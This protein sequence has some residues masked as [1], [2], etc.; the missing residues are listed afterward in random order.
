M[1]LVLWDLAGEDKFL[2]V[3]PSHLRGLAGYLLVAD[4]T[5]RTTIEQ[6]LALRERHAARLDAVPGLLLINKRDLEG[7][8]QVDA[9]VRADI[10]SASL[11]SIDTSALTGAGVEQAFLALAERLV[12]S[13]PGSG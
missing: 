2:S 9:A 5:R 11:P 8:G 3:Q 6:A 13:G 4:G 10:E 7:Q 1:G 12:S